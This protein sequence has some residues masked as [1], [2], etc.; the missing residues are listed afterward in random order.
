[1]SKSLFERT[2]LSSDPMLNM[3]KLELELIP[4]PVYSLKKIREVEF[5]IFLIDIVKPTIII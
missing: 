5:L 1:M 2:V 4:D 3:T